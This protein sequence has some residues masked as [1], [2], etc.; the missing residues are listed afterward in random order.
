MRVQWDEGN[1]D[2]GISRGWLDF[3]NPTLAGFRWPVIEI[4]GAAPEPRICVMGGVHVNEASGIEAAI[5]LSERIDPDAMDGRISVIPVVN[6]AA[7]GH[8]TSKTPVDGKD[9]H[10]LYP[11][12]R[13]GS[14]SEALAHHL[15]FDWAADAA[16]LIDLHGGDIGEIQSPYVVY[17]RTGDAAVDNR[18]E[19]LARCFDTDW[20]V[21]VDAARSELPGRS[22]TALGRL[23]RAGLVTESGDHAV[24][25]K[26]SAEWH[27]RG[28]LNAARLVGVLGGEIDVDLERRSAVVIEE[29]V[30]TL[31]PTDGMYYPQH[32]PGLRVEKGQKLGE[33]RDGFGRRVADV[34]APSDGIVLWRWCLQF[35]KAGAWI[36]AVGRPRQDEAR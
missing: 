19:A 3:D 27:A 2:R 33:I 18:H 4:V 25:T 16:A 11:G 36:G 7:Q 30:F 28:V 13:D 12:D 26:E 8:Y 34:E 31:A 6:Q 35:A 23:G 24:L 17:Q 20:L 5:T 21:G 9:I 32:E 1:G 15:L 14:F 22:C 29:Y 10:W